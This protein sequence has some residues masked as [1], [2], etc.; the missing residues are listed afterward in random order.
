[1]HYRHV[2]RLGLGDRLGLGLGLGLGRLGL[3]LC[4]LGLRLGLG[5]ADKCRQRASVDLDEQ[6]CTRVR[7]AILPLDCGYNPG[8]NSRC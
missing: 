7:C 1:V 2:L 8:V 6:V 3:G 5:G 4:R